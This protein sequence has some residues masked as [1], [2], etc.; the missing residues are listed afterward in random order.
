M[1][2][3][4]VR[5]G[6]VTHGSVVGLGWFILGTQNT[7]IIA[8]QGIT[9]IR[10]VTAGADDKLIEHSVRAIQRRPMMPESE[11]SCSGVKR[12]AL[13]CLFITKAGGCSVRL[14]QPPV[15][16]R[17]D[18]GMQIPPSMIRAA[19]ALGLRDYRA[20][21]YKRTVDGSIPVYEEQD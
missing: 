13:T 15:P 11:T 8:A 18:E 21:V 20:R 16:E 17:I 19:W 6:R 7:D 1:S 4:L 9:A 3:T 2:A 10:N 5:S 12:T 14:L